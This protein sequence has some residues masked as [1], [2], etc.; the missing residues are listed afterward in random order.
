MRLRIAT[1]GLRIAAAIVAAAP[2]FAQSQ[3]T[4]L[5]IRFNSGQSIVPV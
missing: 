4:E 1:C 2:L 3:S 5:H